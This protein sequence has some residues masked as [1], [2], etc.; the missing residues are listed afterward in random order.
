MVEKIQRGIVG[1][2]LGIISIV[3]AFFNSGAGIV[4]GVIG[5]IQSKKEKS[6]LAKKAKK[7]STIGLVLSIIFFIASLVI[8]YLYTKNI[9][10][11]FPA[12]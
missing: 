12:I 6:E 11:N 4:L 5:I 3:M 7:L 8:T 2:V 10:Q 9:I 1:Y